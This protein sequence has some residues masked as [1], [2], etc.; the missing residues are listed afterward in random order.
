MTYILFRPSKVLSVEEYINLKSG[1]FESFLEHVKAGKVDVE[2]KY[3]FCPQLKTNLK[4]DL[5]KIIAA[6][7]VTAEDEL[8]RVYEYLAKKT[9]WDCLKL[10]YYEY[11]ECDS[12]CELV[13]SDLIEK[14]GEILYLWAAMIVYFRQ[15]VD[16]LTAETMAYMF[17]TDN[18]VTYYI[19]GEIMDGACVAHE[20]ILNNLILQATVY[21]F[22]GMGVDYAYVYYLSQ[23]QEKEHRDNVLEFRQTLG[24]LLAEYMMKKIGIFGKAY[25]ASLIQH[26]I[27]RYK[28]FEEISKQEGGSSDEG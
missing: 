6:V 8:M 9:Y 16:F 11:G 22:G 19:Y 1:S 7:K 27:L 24:E 2:K 4:E 15:F 5:E 21:P 18:R 13:C 26:T 12:D 3:D 14:Y 25:Y 23:S 10:Y 17:L 28:R 20:A